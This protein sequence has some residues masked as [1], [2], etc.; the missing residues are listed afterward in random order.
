MVTDTQ[1]DLEY[2]FLIANGVVALPTDTLS[3]LWRKW[4]I[5]N[6]PIT[7]GGGGDPTMG[8]DLSGLA[9][10]AQIVAGAVGATEVSAAIEKTANKGAASGYAGLDGSSKVPIANLPT[11]T[12]ASTVAIGNDARFT[13]AE[14]TV[15]KGAASGYAGLD[16]AG[17]VPIAQLPTGTSSSTVVV[18][19]DSRFTA[20]EQIA[21]KG[22]AS[23]YAPLDSGSKVPVAN[24]AAG[25]MIAVVKTG[26]VWPGGTASTGVRP[27]SRS[28]VVVAWIGADPSPAIVA[29]GTG[30]ML[31]NVDLRFITQ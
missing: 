14:Q 7:G 6:T 1:K 16:G 24:V 11:G 31:D 19:N 25:A 26:G 23:G 9:S 18:G 13:A 17:K 20:A 30:G 22:A 4:L 2:K 15:N 8:G 21:N 27:T 29:S 28:D 12:S 5:A 3:D 10:N